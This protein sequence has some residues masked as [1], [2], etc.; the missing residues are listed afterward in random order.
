VLESESVLDIHHYSLLYTPCWSSLIRPCAPIRVNLLLVLKQTILLRERERVSFFTVLPL[1]S[2]E[3]V[4][5]ARYSLEAFWF[6]YSVLK[7]P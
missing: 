3:K 4:S 6:Y 1:R 2:L 7:F 5:V